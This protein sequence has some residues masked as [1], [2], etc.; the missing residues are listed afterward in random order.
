MFMN[1]YLCFSHQIIFL[2]FPNKIFVDF[3]SQHSSK[4]AVVN[5]NEIIMFFFKGDFFLGRDVVLLLS[6]LF[7]DTVRN[8]RSYGVKTKKI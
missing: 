1:T 7:S 2:F 6:S 5:F 4:N 3:G 8:S